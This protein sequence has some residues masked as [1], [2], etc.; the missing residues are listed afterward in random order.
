MPKR[1]KKTLERGRRGGTQASLLLK[2]GHG[3]LEATKKMEKGEASSLSS[4]F[5]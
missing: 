5:W 1:K 3:A 2:L 4:E